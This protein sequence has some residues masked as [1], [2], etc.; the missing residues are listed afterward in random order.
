MKTG[1]Q[2]IGSTTVENKCRHS[3]K[4]IART[5]IYPAIPLLGLYQKKLKSG[6]H[7]NSY[8]SMFTAVLFTI[9][10]IKKPRCPSMDK[11]VKIYTYT[12]EHY[13]VIKNKILPFLST[14]TDLEGNM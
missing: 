12:L 1:F 4:I 7:R 14:Y 11:W 8:I 10:K 9:V 3:S 13:S 6:S 2:Q 5:T